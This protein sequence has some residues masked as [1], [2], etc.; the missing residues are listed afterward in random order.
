MYFLSLARFLSDSLTH[1]LTY[2]LTHAMTP[3]QSP[4][5]TPSLPPSLFAIQ[6]C[7]FHSANHHCASISHA[8]LSTYPPGIS[9]HSIHTGVLV[10]WRRVHD[11]RDKGTRRC[12]RQLPN[13][14][15]QSWHVFV[16]RLRVM[17]KKEGAMRIH[18]L[19]HSTRE[20]HFLQDTQ[21]GLTGDFFF[22]NKISSSSI[23]YR[24]RQ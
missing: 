17:G 15:K 4:S 7:H 10:L 1:S 8:Y 21:H 6:P 23:E 16:H 12:G 24:V 9:V 22:E 11:A 2:S 20:I 3:S 18:T 14:A 13:G 19:L 5:L